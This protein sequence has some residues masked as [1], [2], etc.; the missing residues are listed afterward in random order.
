VS[1]DWQILTD[2]DSALNHE[3]EGYASH[4]S[5]NKG[6]TIRF[7]LNVNATQTVYIDIY[8]LGYYGG[9]GGR[10][11]GLKV[12]QWGNGCMGTIFYK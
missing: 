9:D 11:S 7:H 12:I 1:R 5:V 4:S 10:S 6:E 2:E 8:R 3:V